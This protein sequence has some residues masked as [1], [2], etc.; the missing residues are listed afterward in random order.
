MSERTPQT[1]LIALVKLV[2]ATAVEVAGLYWW[3]KLDDTHYWWA[4]ASLVA[5]EAVETAL[6]RRATATEGRKR[7]GTLAPAGAGNRHFRRVQ[8]LTSIT[9]IMEVAIW[10]LWLWIAED[11]GWGVA[12]AA[13]LVLMHLKHHIEVVTVK[14]MRFREGIFTF[15]G[16]VASAMEVGG[17]VACLQLLDDGHPLLAAAALSV[18]VLL[19]HAIQIDVLR[20]EMTARDIRVPR[21]K[22]WKR[23]LR[24]RP[25]LLY[26]FT[27]FGRFWRRVQ[28]IR[29]LELLF[30]RFAISGLIGVVE[31]RPNPLSTMAPYTSWSSLTDRTYSGRHLPPLDPTAT[32][33]ATTEVGPPTAHA[34]GR[35]FERGDMIECPKSTVLFAFFAQWFTDGFLRSARDAKPG[36]LRDTQ[37]NESTHEIDLSQL[38]GLNREMTRQLRATPKDRD[39]VSSR[40]CRGLLKH[41]MINGEE[42][43]PFYCA[44][45]EPK[46]EFDALLVPVGFKDIIP[47]HKRRLFA[48]GTDITNV[49]ALACN[50]LFLREHNRIARRLGHENPRWDDD[51]VFETARNVLTV[52]LLKIVI[53]EYINHITPNQ[54]RFRLVPNSFPDARWHRQNWMAIEFNLLYRWH[55]LVPPTFHLNGRELQLPETLWDT[56]LLTEAGLGPFIAAASSQPGGR[57]GLLNTEKFLVTR[58]EVPS[59][60]Q[61]RVARLYSYN[62]YRRLCGLLPKAHFDE[63]SSDKR[64]QE[65]LAKLYGSVEDVEF[66]AGLFAEDLVPGGVLPE[67]MGTMVAFDAFSQVLTNPLFAPRVYNDETFSPTG[68]EIIEETATLAALVQRNTPPGTENYFVSLTRRDYTR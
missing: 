21:D 19:E 20:W 40:A 22:R 61:A 59:I 12:A 26:L 58:A 56:K 64:I 36:S 33:P 17:A 44:G 39:G 9:G 25:V 13:L 51:R 53:E 65:G 52:V 49:G 29:R 10:V 48:L 62:D 4:L 32:R 7:W 11:V 47:E 3:L 15:H 42:Y 24:R 23:P 2:F 54:L 28:R 34:V 60:R 45:E 41:Q 6:F 66:Y 37:R 18:G 55:S 1:R 5:G 30:N 43:P 63:I 46:P 31:P 16:T 50:V 35:L 68:R 67:L 8:G 38:Y 14:D 27:H 57:I